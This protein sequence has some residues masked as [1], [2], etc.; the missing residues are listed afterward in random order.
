MRFDSLFLFRFAEAILFFSD[1]AL[2]DKLTT[3]VYACHAV[4]NKQIAAEKRKK[5]V[6]HESKIIQASFSRHNIIVQ[7]V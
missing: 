2:F 3:L 4:R 5:N 6:Q 1:G 7:R